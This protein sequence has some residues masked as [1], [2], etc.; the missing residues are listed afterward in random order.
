MVIVSCIDVCRQLLHKLAAR[1]LIRDYEDGSLD[2][3]EAEHEVR[4]CV[5]AKTSHAHSVQR[6]NE[7]SHTSAGEESRAEAFH[8]RLKQAVLHPVSVH[9]LRGRRGKGL[10]STI[11]YDTPSWRPATLN[12][13]WF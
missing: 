3:D 4:L 11:R 9:Q 6:C 10:C 1:A 12:S 7:R 13:V 5:R 2:T 8:R